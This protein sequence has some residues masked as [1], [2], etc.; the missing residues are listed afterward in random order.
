MS[1][2]SQVPG[3]ASGEQVIRATVPTPF[4]D[5]AEGLTGEKNATSFG[6]YANGMDGGGNDSMMNQDGPGSTPLTN[7]TAG[8]S[9]GFAMQD[10]SGPHLGQPAHGSGGAGKE[11]GHGTENPMSAYESS[12]Y[13]SGIR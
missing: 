1:D 13:E 8:V 3:V 4:C 9:P 6:T 5:T 10:T 7:A 12:A 11:G 2:S